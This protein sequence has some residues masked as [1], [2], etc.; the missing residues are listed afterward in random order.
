MRSSEA[1]A[2]YIRRHPKCKSVHE[3]GLRVFPDGVTHPTRSYSPFPIQVVDAKGSHK[4]CLDGHDYL[5]WISMHGANLLGYSHPAVTEAVQEQAGH[6]T[7]AAGAHELEVRMAQQVLKLFPSGEKAR[8]TGTGTEANMLAIRLARVYTGRRRLVKFQG[9]FHGWSDV[10][11]VGM[12]AP[13]ENSSNG[14]HPG[15][16]ADTI[17]LP[18]GDVQ[19]LEAAL[20]RRDV[21]CVI[22]EGG[23]AHMGQVPVE[24]EFV[25]ILRSLCTQTGT[26]L[27]FDEV[28]TGFRWAPGGWQQVIGVQPDMTTLAKIA[29]GTLPGGMVLGKADIMDRLSRSLAPNHVS[30][31]GTFNA[32]PLS[33]AAGLATLKI[34][35]TGEPQRI[36]AE[37]TDK[38]KRGMH[39]VLQER[40]VSGAVYGESSVFHVYIGECSQDPTEYRIGPPAT[41]QQ[42][43]AGGMNNQAI[44]NLRQNLI[45]NGV[46]TW[47]R[48]GITNA[49]HTEEDVGRMVEAFA[50]S[51]DTT[52]ED[53]VMTLRK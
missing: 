42:I 43:L 11:D 35:E 24:P 33:L 12:A 53:G 9:H 25:K 6:M 38:V 45:Y 13:F 17:V 41:D 21:A 27:L 32:N 26:V 31:S 51:V 18:R 16:H 19:A 29:M 40:G 50:R 47:V 20:S 49:A 30:Q 48:L 22:I 44:T 7:H 10:V 37:M 2:Q 46:D 36:A 34:A 28:V 23:G 4:Q 15:L 5:D 52:I 1:E 3:E 39:M 14:V 8:F